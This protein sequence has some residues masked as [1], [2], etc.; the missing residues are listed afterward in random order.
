M[1]RSRAASARADDFRDETWPKG[2]TR[3]NR[4]Y[5]FRRMIK[6]K[7]L[8][9]SLGDVSER[10]AIER[11][12]E[13]NTQI[14]A[15]INV[16]QQ[17]RRAKTHVRQF[18]ASF[19]EM[20]RAQTSA[21]TCDRYRAVFDNFNYWLEKNYGNAPV[22]GVTQEMAREYLLARANGPVIP[23]S[24][25]KGTRPQ[26]GRA[27][28]WTMRMERDCLAGLFKEAVRRKL[29]AE[30]PF[31]TIKVS[32]PSRDEVAAA[33]H[34]LSEREIRGLILAAGRLD[35][36]TGDKAN[37]GFRDI[38]EFMLRTGLRDDE[39]RHLEWTDVEFDEELIHVRPKRVVETRTGPIPEKAVRKLARLLRDK[40]P[41]AP[42][43]STERDFQGMTL[44]VR[45]KAD[46]LSITCSAVDMESRRIVFTKEYDWRPKASSGSVPMGRITTQLLS[47]IKSQRGDFSNFVFAHHDGGSCRMKLLDMLK[48]AQKIAGIPGRLR[49]HDLRHTCAATLRRKGAPLETIMG[50]MRHADIRETLIYA[51]YSVEEGRR[52]IRL[53]DEV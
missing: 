23:D 7:R 44:F 38:V 30:N 11:A 1:A 31:E 33:H 22:V 20:K 45:K 36:E 50:I 24:E 35:D 9:I 15:G 5:R 26:S 32:K 47:A 40:T 42:V 25:R 6:G 2:L 49:I 43:F 21:N 41:A 37:A 3:R 29:I 51:P 14:A 52:A 28:P 12:N 10:V 18:V 53:L 34:I 46:L 39:V 19:M 48:K 16:S 8:S 27:S 13:L 4:C 17:A